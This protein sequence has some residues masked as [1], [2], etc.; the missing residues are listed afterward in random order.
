MVLSLIPAPLA[1]LSPALFP[2][3]M[4]AQASGE[5]G[6]GFTITLDRGKIADTYNGIGALSAGTGSRLLM[7]YPEQQ[8]DEMLDYMFKPGYGASLDVFKFE[9]GG[10]VV[11]S[12]GT[13]PSP[14]RTLDEFNKAVD[15]KHGDNEHGQIYKL[16]IEVA[17]LRIKP[18][19]E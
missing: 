2:E 5:E 13:E 7:D 14:M 16:L 1:A 8:R 17:K 15:K 12:W 6:S 11:S 3:P 9:I 19:K 10:D 4:Q 18:G